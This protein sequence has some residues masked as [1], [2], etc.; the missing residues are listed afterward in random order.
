VKRVLFTGLA[1]AASL[2]A[3]AGPAL[4]DTA[5]S[6]NWAGYAVGA[7]P[8]ADGT[9]PVPLS[10][11][12][13]TGTWVEPAASCTTDSATYAAFWVGLGG[14]S[15]GS[16]ALEQIGTEV[17]CSSSGAKRHSVWYELVPAEPVQLKLKIR[18]GDRISATV[19]VTGQTVSL[20]LRNLTRKTI[21]T[22]KL[23]MDAPDVSS[24]EWIAEA[25]SACDDFGRCD[26]LPL[27]N[28]GTVTFGNIAAIGNAHP[29]TL[30]D[31]AWTASAIELI[32]TGGANRFFGAGDPLGDGV[33]ALPG[34][35]SADGRTFSVSWRHDLTPG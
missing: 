2:A 12:S 11:S 31:A 30:T 29:G 3:A 21:F 27:T 9:D 33:G 16:Q 4:A 32:S 19:T 14:F 7:A 26:V 25:P 24:A 34:D 22:R 23:T 6:S 20:R 35:A 5:T 13:V 15:D 8:T 1:A 18:A 10:F 17:D 28:F